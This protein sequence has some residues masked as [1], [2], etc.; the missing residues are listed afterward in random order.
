MNVGSCLFC[1]FNIL[2]CLFK[3]S[4]NPMMINDDCQTPLDVAR[5]KGYINVVRAIEV[6]LRKILISY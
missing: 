4:A 2:T 3:L 6:C 5:A 1:V